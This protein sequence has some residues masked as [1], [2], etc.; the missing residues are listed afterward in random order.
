MI[1]VK[2]IPGKGKG[3]VAKKLLPKGI[4]IETAPV[5]SFPVE[6]W[7]IIKKTEIFKYCFVI[8]RNYR[9]HKNV[10]GYIVF[11]LSSFCNH[12]ESPN[13]YIKWT[14]DEIGLWAHLIALTDIQPEEEVL[15][16][17]TNIDEYPANEFI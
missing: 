12:S 1:E 6:E 2:K 3:V 8:P 4:L 14:Q 5:S 7:T 16:F 11:G 15:I 10:D 13:A 9:E 17:Y